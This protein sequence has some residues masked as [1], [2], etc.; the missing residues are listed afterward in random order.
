MFT[1]FLNRTVVISRS[2]FY[3]DATCCIGI[4]VG[5]LVLL[6][7]AF[8]AAKFLIKAVLVIIA[9]VAVGLVVWWFLA[10]QHG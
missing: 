4:G 7:L 9:L 2:N 10:R 1:G 5:A 6:Y 3:D 8:K